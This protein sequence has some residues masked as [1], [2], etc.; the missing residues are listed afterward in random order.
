MLR[1]SADLAALAESAPEVAAFN[2]DAIRLEGVTCFQLTA[3]MRNNA[4]EP[5]VPSGLHPTIPAALSLQVLDVAESPWGGFAMALLRVSCR[6]GV[7]ARGFTRAAIAS[8]EEAC[9]GLRESL[10]YP[11]QVGSIDFRHGYDGVSVQVRSARDELMLMVEAL[12]PE[13]MALD[14]VQYTGSMNLA[15]T[16]NGLRLMQVEM[17][18]EANQV[19]RLTARIEAFDGAAF[20]DQ[21][22]SPTRVIAASVVSMD[23]EFPPVR[24]VCK[25]DELAFTGT[26][27]VR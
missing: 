24:F 13:P 16:P 10:G 6:S 8:S 26:E 15:H 17:N 25:P 3:E 1:G 7:R 27:S 12:D 21:R 18:T 11:A 4:R 5:L 20:G 19:E 23:A 14:D 2:P 9:A 22:I